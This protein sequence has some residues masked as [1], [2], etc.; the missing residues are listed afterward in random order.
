MVAIG[1]TNGRRGTEQSMNVHDTERLASLVAGG[2]LVAAS[3]L[4]SGWRR[5]ALALSGAG[6]VYRGWTGF[7]HLYSLL[8][9][10]TREEPNPLVA[11]KASEGYKVTKSITIHRP[12]EELFRFWRDVENLPQVMNHL[13]SVRR[14]GDNRSR[15]EA[16]AIL[17][18][19]VAWDAEIYN[20]RANELIAWRSLAGSDVDTAGSVHFRRRADGGTDLEISLKYNPPAGKAGATIAGILGEGLEEKLEEDLE[21]FK[22]AMESGDAFSQTPAGGVAAHRPAEEALHPPT[23]T[24][25]AGVAP[26]AGVGEIIQPP[27]ITPAGG[28]AGETL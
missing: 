12:A 7:C 1:T 3:L 22:R 26:A 8:G 19:T 24:R 25:Q 16:K 28:N 14:T 11:V 9:V 13:V 6:M 10:N 23:A 5:W 4:Q 20:E 15:W 18:S 17:G 27:V 2:G 21:Q